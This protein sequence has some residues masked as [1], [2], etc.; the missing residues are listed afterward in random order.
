MVFGILREFMNL[1][2]NN[3]LEVNGNE[4]IGTGMVVI[5]GNSVEAISTSFSCSYLS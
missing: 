5:R 4:K 1:V 3:K 2:V